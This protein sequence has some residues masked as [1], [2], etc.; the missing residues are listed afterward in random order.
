[1][2]QPATTGCIQNNNKNNVE[3]DNMNDFRGIDCSPITLIFTDE[4]L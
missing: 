1:M 2:M 3:I 4:K